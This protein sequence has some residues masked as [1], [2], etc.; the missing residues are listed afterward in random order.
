MHTPVL[1]QE[2]IHGLQIAPNSNCI[3]GTVGLGGHARLMLEKAAPNGTLIGV[4][5]D[6]TSLMLASEELRE[7]GD[8]FIPVHD[9]YARILDHPDVLKQ[10]QP[11]S[12][13]LIDLG[14]S[15]RQLDAEER[16]FSFL[17]PGPLDM[18][19]DTLEETPTAAELLD[20][21]SEEELRILFKTY[22]EEPHANRIAR[23][24]VK[25]RAVESITTTQ[26]LAQL[27]ESVVPR[28]PQQ[29]IHPA[30]R[31]FQALR[32]AV[33]R[34]LEELE[35]FL[36]VAVEVLAPQGRLAVISFHSLE[37]R[38]VKKFFRKESVDCICPP[39]LPECRCDHRSQLQILTKKP[40]TASPEEIQTNPR[41]RSAK[42]RIIQKM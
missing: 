8:R 12:A 11:I 14:L 21:Q 27:V 20:S 17:A 39:E 25:Q 31:V 38:I 4:D 9:S 29:R 2:V 32:I 33:N 7:F 6:R 1:L 19:F 23:A 37:D 3:D 40:I 28:R 42:L 34:E 30:T 18:R 36:P 15:S 16:G 5:R 24:I 13:I 10:A 26:D 41:A 22:G 35:E